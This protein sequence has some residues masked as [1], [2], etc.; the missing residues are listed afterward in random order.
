MVRASPYSSEREPSWTPN[1]HFPL[2]LEVSST[3]FF[4]A[5]FEHISGIQYDWMLWNETS[6]NVA[7]LRMMKVWQKR[8]IR[9]AYATIR[10]AQYWQGSPQKKTRPYPRPLLYNQ[11]V[12]YSTKNEKTSCHTFRMPQLN[13]ARKC[14]MPNY[15]ISSFWSDNTL[16]QRYLGEFLQQQ[17]CC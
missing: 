9:C 11:I 3:E 5:F 7:R 13:Q 2:S 1:H 10:Q 15:L 17:A 6:G 14:S 8:Q 16:L 4:F 12:E